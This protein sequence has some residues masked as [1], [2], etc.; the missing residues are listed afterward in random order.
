M[1]SKIKY[2]CLSILLPIAFC[3][4]V[5]LGLKKLITRKEVVKSRIWT[6]LCVF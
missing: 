6:Y 1:T 4:L 3:Y 5:Y 2:L